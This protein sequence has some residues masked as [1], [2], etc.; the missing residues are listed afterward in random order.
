MQ[1]YN[2]SYNKNVYMQTKQHLAFFVNRQ[3]LSPVVELQVGVPQGFVLG[4]LFA[5]YCS[6]VRDVKVF[7]TDDTQLHL[8]MSVDN[9]A[10]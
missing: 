2:H 3:Y 9:T 4:P 8:A 5:V 10:A 7:A 6:P 1:L